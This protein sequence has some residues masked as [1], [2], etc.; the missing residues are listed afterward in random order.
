MSCT[1]NNLSSRPV[2]LFNSNIVVSPT[3]TN[4]LVEPIL[5]SL[6]RSP[7]KSIAINIADLSIITAQQ[8]VLHVDVSGFTINQILSVCLT[9]KLNQIIIDPVHNATLQAGYNFDITTNII[10]MVLES[11]GSF[12][13]GAA[14]I[15]IVYI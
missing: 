15:Y 11:L 8:F 12:T 6:Q 10:S 7:V 4:I 14:T 9:N 5:S 1:P 2:L 13:T 3:G